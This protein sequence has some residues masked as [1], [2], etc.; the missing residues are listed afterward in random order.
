MKLKQPERERER[1]NART[2]DM[3][4]GSAQFRVLSIKMLISS[5][6]KHK[7]TIINTPNPA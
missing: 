3:S 6:T 2:G 4:Q 5:S 7:T 1:E